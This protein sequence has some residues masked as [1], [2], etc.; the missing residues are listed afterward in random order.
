MWA[1]QKLMQLKGWSSTELA[2]QLG[3]SKSMI[4]RILA[5]ARLSTT[6]QVLVIDGQIGSADAY[7]I[8]RLEGDARQAAVCLAIEG[9]LGRENLEQL[10]RKPAEKSI[11]K[12]MVRL[13]FGAFSGSFQSEEA[14]ALP[15]LID[16]LR[17]AIRECKHAAKTGLDVTTLSRILAD[18]NRFEREGGAVC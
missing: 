1:Y 14:F 17:Q 4:T 12:R 15:D 6:E 8:S 9:R 3:V 2:E 13:E 5:L 16:W 10:A 11:R 18:R 7:A